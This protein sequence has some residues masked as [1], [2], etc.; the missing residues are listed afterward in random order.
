M[1]I[2]PFADQDLDASELGGE[3]TWAPPGDTGQVSSYQA[4]SSLG[5]GK[6]T[7][8]TVKSLGVNMVAVTME[9]PLVAYTHVV[10]YTISS[11][12]EQTTPA[13]LLIEDSNSSVIGLSFIDRDL[14]SLQVG[15]LISF[16]APSDVAQVKFYLASSSSSGSGGIK[17]GDTVN[18]GTNE[19]DFLANTALASK[20]FVAVYCKSSLAEATTPESI[21]LIDSE[22]HV[23]GI[24]FEDKDL[25]L[26][27]LGG[28]VTWSGAG[29]SVVV[30][31]R[32][33][34]GVEAFF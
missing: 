20:A 32:S 23:T 4:Q 28:N 34:C 17:V 8:G 1:L 6:V 26:S 30:V 24:V 19:I 10:V 11:L 16:Q 25:D 9:T 2:L 21:D 13:A 7:L 5:H 15:G 27:Q 31:L 14:D 18:V 22:A 33:C 29:D 12:A 3:V